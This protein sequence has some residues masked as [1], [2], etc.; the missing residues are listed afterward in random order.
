MD[1]NRIGHKIAEARKQKNMSQAQLGQLLFI[2]PQA[3]GKWERG[4]SLPDVLMLGRLA[5][6][7][8]VDLNYFSD[9]FRP[10]TMSSKGEP[11][12]PVLSRDLLTNFSGNQLSETDFAGVIAH[13]RRFHGSAMHGAN[14]SG[15]DLTDSSFSSC[16]MQETIFDKANLTDCTLS[17]ND[18]AGAS[19]DQTLLIR[20]EI[21]KSHLAQ[22]TFTKV[23]FTGARLGYLDLRKTVFEECSFTNM[24][25]K[26]CDLRGLCFDGQ[27]FTDVKFD[28]S[29]LNEAS[30]KGATFQ[31]VSFRPT[32]ALTS[33]YYRAL[34]TICFE[35]AQMDKLTYAALQ[36]VGADLSGVTT[37]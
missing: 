4:E 30:F 14:F 36:G 10:V 7:L 18:L 15:A 6:V 31:N 25:F 33:K 16:N 12:A 5:E 32:Y 34:R 8:E 11:E 13:Q 20:T 26:Y 3:V 29:A 17:T 28:R 27:V 37:I 23:E 9:N 21:N 2:S 1:T 19:F 35:E 22:V 24:D